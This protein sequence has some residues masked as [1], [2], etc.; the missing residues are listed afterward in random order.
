MVEGLTCGIRHDGQEFDVSSA[1]E[2]WNAAGRRSRVRARCRLG[3]HGMRD[4]PIGR[5][6]CINKALDLGGCELD[7]VGIEDDWGCRATRLL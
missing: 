2:S 7:V 5:G 6:Y 3:A 1:V 4:D